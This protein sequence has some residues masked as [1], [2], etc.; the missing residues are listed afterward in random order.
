MREYP[1]CKYCNEPIFPGCHEH[2]HDLDIAIETHK[3]LRELITQVKF[4]RQES[5]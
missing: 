4:L 1:I 2:D 3:L 5:N